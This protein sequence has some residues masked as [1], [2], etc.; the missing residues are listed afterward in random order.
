MPDT[1]GGI[2]ETG[3]SVAQGLVK[4]AALPLF[5]VLLMAAVVTGGGTIIPCVSEEKETR[6]VELLITSASPLS[7]LAGKLLGVV[8]TG[9][10]HI[11]V[12]IAVGALVTPVIFDR[13]PTAGQLAISGV[14][15]SSWRSAS[16]SATSS[17][18]PSPCSSGRS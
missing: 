12:W 4:L 14:R 9:L 11:A 2:G 6:M 5:A 10:A 15:L 1:P 18:P 3:G 13:I 16:C 17:S 8:L 7:I